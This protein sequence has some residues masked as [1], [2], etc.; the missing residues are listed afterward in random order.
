MRSTNHMVHFFLSLSI[1]L[2]EWTQS[3]KQGRPM[4]IIP[5][6]DPSFIAGLINYGSLL[7]LISF[8]CIIDTRIADLMP[9]DTV[10]G[11]VVG[12]PDSC[13]ARSSS[14]C[15]ASACAQRDAKEESWAS[16]FLKS[17]SLSLMGLPWGLRRLPLPRD[18]PTALARFHE[19]NRDN[20]CI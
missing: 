1:R 18:Q 19:Y 20:I 11:S 8:F 3:H 16:T 9:S 2:E 4:L 10:A 15:V 7:L 5:K 6:N 17:L 12:R 13:R 14:S